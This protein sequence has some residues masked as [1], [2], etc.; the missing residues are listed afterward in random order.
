MDEVEGVA[1][2]LDCDGNSLPVY[3]IYQFINGSFTVSLKRRRT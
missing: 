2:E 3:G 1:V